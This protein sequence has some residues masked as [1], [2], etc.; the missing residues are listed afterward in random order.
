MSRNF[1][2][3]PDPYGIVW[4]ADPLMVTGTQTFTANRAQ[5]TRVR[6]GGTISKIRIQCTVSSGNVCVGVY[7]NTGSGLSAMPGARVAT[8]GSLASAGTGARD[9]SLGASVYVN[10]GDWLAFVTDNTSITLAYIGVVTEFGG[11]PSVWSG[12]S[13]YQD[14]AFPLPSTATPTSGATKPV[15]L[16]GVP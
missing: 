16:I 15:L 13:A 11:T 12:R 5:Y 1:Y 2:A 9:Y 7:A 8:S 14:T 10:P 3:V 4:N 6:T